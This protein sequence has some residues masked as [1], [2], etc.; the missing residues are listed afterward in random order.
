MSDK[1]INYLARDYQ[2]I[3]SELIKFSKMYYPELTDN[4]NDAS[5]GSWFLDLVSVIGDNLSYHTD[6]MYQENN[7]DSANLKSSVINAAKINGVKI[8]GPKAS[9]CEVELSCVLPV[10]S[11]NINSPSWKDAPIIKMGSVVGNSSY[12]FE[13]I[14]DVNFAEQFN[15]D[16]FS[17]RKYTPVRNSNGVITGY[18][19]NKS[20]LVMGGSNK[21]Y[22]KVL[23]QNEIEPF[24]EIVLPK[25]VVLLKVEIVFQTLLA[26]NYT[27]I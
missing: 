8:P 23:L 5:V 25:V 17:N 15:S 26:V 24:M 22:K 9:M 18:T 2:D 16:G 20:T 13:L 3:K 12:Q 4:Y 19:V 21:V 7:I 11:T 1:K 14:E 6:R 10:D 27:R